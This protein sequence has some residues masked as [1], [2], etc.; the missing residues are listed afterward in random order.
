MR[1]SAG[2]VPA[3]IP[4]QRWRFELQTRLVCRHA[5]GLF[6]RLNAGDVSPGVAAKLKQLAGALGAGDVAGATSIQVRFRRQCSCSVSNSRACAER[7]RISL[8]AG[9]TSIQVR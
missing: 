2:V 5:G 3:P 7:V 1:G 6:W 9:T 4:C 8:I